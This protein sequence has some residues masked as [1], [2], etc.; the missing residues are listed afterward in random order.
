M[1]Y[2]PVNIKDEMLRG[3]MQG[4]S[5]QPTTPDELQVYMGQVYHLL[6]DDEVM[7]LVKD[8]EDLTPMLPTISHMLRTS[9][10]D[11]KTRFVMKLRARRA[12]RLQLMVL[13]TPNLVSQAKFDSWLNFIFAAI[14]DTDAGWRGKLVT[15][16][17][18]S[19]KVEMSG[20]GRKKFLGV[21]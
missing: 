9:N 6:K 2:P 11:K 19:Y 14:D 15:E 12:L 10:L 17:I 8:D 4:E 13:K 18:K 3:V 21:F 20:A 7:K 1:T 16:R 5:M